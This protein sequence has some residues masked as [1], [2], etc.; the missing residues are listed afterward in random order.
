M[1][2][3]R[4][5][6]REAGVVEIFMMFFFESGFIKVE[7][8]QARCKR[9]PTNGG[10]LFTSGKE[11]LEK[12]WLPRLTKGR[13]SKASGGPHSTNGEARSKDPAA[14]PFLVFLRYL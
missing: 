7:C 13:I 12:K 10:D 6:S 11:E 9:I 5:I 14:G 4:M 8:V 1:Q 3:D 2:S